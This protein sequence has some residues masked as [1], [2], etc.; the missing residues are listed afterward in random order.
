[1]NILKELRESKSLTQTQV[2]NAVG[3]SQ[4]A[5][6]LIENGQN[7]P[8]LETALKFSA[9]FEMPVNKIFLSEKQL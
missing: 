5:Y 4:Q 7:S 1:M 6:S 9:F 8:S 2:A 3:I